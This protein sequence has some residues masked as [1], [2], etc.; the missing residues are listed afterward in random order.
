MKAAIFVAYDD[1]WSGRSLTVAMPGG[2]SYST[3][4]RKRVYSSV[5]QLLTYG[6]N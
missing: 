3:S 5:N 6:A 2:Q 4:R 1:V